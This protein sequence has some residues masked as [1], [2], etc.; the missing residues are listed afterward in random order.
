MSESCLFARAA[1][2]CGAGYVFGKETMALELA[3]G[4]SGGKTN[5]EIV[6]SSWNDGN[7]LRRVKS[8]DL[9]V[10]Q[11]RLGFISAT[12]NWDCVRMTADQMWRWPGLLFDYRRFLR[13]S[14]LRWIIHT[15]WHHLLLLWPFIKPD[16]DLF[17]LHESIPH[18]SQYQRVF[19]QLSKR[20]YCF[21]PVSHAVAHSL[22]QIGVPAEKIRVIHNGIKDPRPAVSSSSK[23]QALRVGIVGQVGVW[24]GHEDL[25]E[26]FAKLSPNLHPIELHIFGSGTKE[27][28]VK[29]KTQADALGIAKQIIWHGFVSDRTAIYTEMDV[30]VVPSRGADPLPTVAIEAAF[31]GLPVIASD[32]G[33]LPE[34]VEDGVSGLLAEPENPNQLAE[35]LNQ[36]LKDSVLRARMGQA[37]RLRAETLFSRERFVNDFV[38]LLGHGDKIENLR[39]K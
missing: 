26:A 20:L 13:N 36:L 5:V 32:R 16:R 27:F 4:L 14:K 30:C 2:V 33:G 7:F 38:K 22:R 3:S 39:T 31:F 10:H 12:L 15:N 24:K 29:L 35:K 34:I 18:K 6:T 17:W 23:R 28:E 9:R 19:G 8:L 21:V 37:A 1:I 25:L 11:M